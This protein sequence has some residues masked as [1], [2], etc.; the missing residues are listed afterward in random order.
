[1]ITQTKVGIIVFALAVLLGP[2]YTVDGYSI[3][4]NL[5]SE[6]GAQHTPNNFIMICAFIAFGVGIVIDGLKKFQIPLLPFILFGLAMVIVGIFPHK[7]LD[8]SQ[9]FNTMYHNLHGIVASIAGTAITVGFIW[10][11]FRTQGKQRIVCFYMALIATTL[12]ILMLSIPN[13]KGI[14]QRFMYLNILG[15]LWLKY[16]IILANKPLHKSLYE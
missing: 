10:Q 13:Y 4:T 12:P 5:V 7:P 1:M 11:G 8:A 2:L 14:I 3:V 6:L 16:P 15:W 9:S